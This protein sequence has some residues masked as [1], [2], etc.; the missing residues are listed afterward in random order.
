MRYII[1]NF[2]RRANLTLSTRLD[3]P[4]LNLDLSLK[5]NRILFQGE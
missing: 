1:L 2:K 4:I 5:M 3:T